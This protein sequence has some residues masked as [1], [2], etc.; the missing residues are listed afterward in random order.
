[1]TTYTISIA[2]LWN[3]LTKLC[4]SPE[5]LEQ[6]ESE[7]NRER[8]D[9]ARS[10]I[11][12]FDHI[13]EAVPQLSIAI[14]FYYNNF[15]YVNETDFGFMIF[16]FTITQTL[17]PMILSTISIIKGIYTGIKACCGL[18][19]WKSDELFRKDNTNVE[20]NVISNQDTVIPKDTNDTNFDEQNTHGGVPDH[21]VEKSVDDIKSQ[22]QTEP[23]EEPKTILNLNVANANPQDHMRHLQALVEH[24]ENQG[25]TL[26]LY[27]EETDGSIRT[28]IQS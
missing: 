2:S 17:I 7:K 16:G 10:Y 12:I 28:I 15:D 26:N 23:N 5:D 11:E 24:F 14:V 1:M 18:K 9:L 19:V 27:K 3:A 13:G 8:V 22:I 20:M 6:L 4:L 21:Q 25:I